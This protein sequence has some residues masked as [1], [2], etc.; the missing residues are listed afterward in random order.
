MAQ[1]RNDFDVVV[2][3][4]GVAGLSAALALG[5]S[6]IRGLV[7]SGGPPRNSRA[8]HAHNFLTQDGTSPSEL[9]RIGRDQLAPYETMEVLDLEISEIIRADGAFR[10]VAETGESWTAPKLV[11]ATGLRDQLP[12]V[13]GIKERWGVSV[14]HCPFCHGW[15]VRD[16]VLAVYGRDDMA[17]ELCVLAKNWSSKVTLCTDGQIEMTEG[18]AERLERNGIFILNSKV[19]RIEGVGETLERVVFADG[20]VLPCDALFVRP[21]RRQRSDLAAKLGCALSEQGYIE[22]DEAGQTSVEGVYAA[23]DAIEAGF[24]ILPFA[25]Y[26]GARAGIGVAKA[27]MAERFA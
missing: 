12:D 25:S 17:Y 18:R 8:P 23:G 14:L 21:I 10:A 1:T 22:V 3:G 7:L 24:Q 20:N 15:E 6:R 16:R 27:F 26:S 4:G 2:V 13:P 9:L 5:R 19:D 11:L